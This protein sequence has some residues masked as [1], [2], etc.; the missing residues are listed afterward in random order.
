MNVKNHDKTHYKFMGKLE[1]F[2]KVMIGSF[3][4]Q[5]HKGKWKRIWKLGK[6]ESAMGSSTYS[7]IILPCKPKP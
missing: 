1:G 2:P 4:K 6:L 5:G 7:S 3:K